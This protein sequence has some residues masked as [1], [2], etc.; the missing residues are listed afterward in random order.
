MSTGATKKSLHS[1]VEV[2][3]VYIPRLGMLTVG[4]LPGY[5]SIGEVTIMWC[6]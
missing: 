2:V 5:E 3:N 1:V 4:H 6:A